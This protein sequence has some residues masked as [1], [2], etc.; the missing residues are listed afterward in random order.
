MPCV[1]CDRIA[2]AELL[3]SNELAAAFQDGYPLS[4]GH[5]LIVPR[6]H[7]ADFLALTAEEQQAIW[8]LVE[9]ARRL[10]EAAGIQPDG[11]NIGVNVGIAAGQTIDH[12]HLH[13]IP[14][15][16]GDVADPRGGV[17]WVVPDRAAYWSAPE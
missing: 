16:R 13:V 5:T 4:P 10:I 2:R 8:A 6:R 1:F 3:I 9:P 17:R 11:Y 15:H 12:A 14:R 7:E